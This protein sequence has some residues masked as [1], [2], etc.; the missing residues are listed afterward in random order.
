MVSSKSGGTRRDRQ[1]PPGRPR[2]LRGRR[3]RPGAARR[4]RHRP[5][6]AARAGRPRGG[7][8]RGL[9]RRPRRRRPLLRAHRLRPRP[10]R[11]GRRRRRRAARRGGRAASRRWPPTTPPRWRSAPSSAAARS[12]GR[13]KL[14]AAAGRRAWSASATGPSSW[15]PSPPASRARACCPS[16]SRPLD[17]PGTEPAADSQ[18][19]VVGTSDAG[20]ARRRHGR[21]RTARRAVPRLG[22]R[23]RRRR[24]GAGAS[25]PSTSRTCRRARTTPARSW[26][27]SRRPC[28]SRCSSRPAS[29][30]TPPATCSPASTTWPARWTRCW[31]RS[32]SAATS[33]SWPTSTG[34]PTP[35]RCGLRAALAARLAHP[36]TFG[37]APRFLH[38]TGQFHKGG[39]QTGAF[40]QVTGAVTEDLEVP[41]R[42]FT[43]GGLQAA[44][45]LGDLRA[46]GSRDR[47]VL[48][49]APHRPPAGLRAL[50]EAARR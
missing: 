34:R 12:A 37:W 38:S 41:G 5:R 35:R 19:V 6:L 14:V 46:L 27:V 18:L 44:Q 1:P 47:P 10:G 40:L 39:P 43:F 49:A 3:H 28:A 23:H 22:V 26:P 29:R 7:H 25:T 21:E 32:P 13:D 16:S 36:V 48:R 17:A 30:C 9:P 24:L 31:R 33:P 42:D 2:R 4:R 15:S 8:P 50:L 11:P 45:A 20:A